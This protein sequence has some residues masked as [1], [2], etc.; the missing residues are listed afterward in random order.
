[1]KVSVVIPVHNGGKYLAQAIDSVLAQ[2]HRDLEL[3]I[4]DDG[5]TDGT[6]AI[7]R[8][9]ASMDQRVRCLSQINR[10]VAA[11]GNRG[12]EEAR[13]EWVARLDA[14]DIFL[15]EKLERQADFLRRNP[16]V[17]IVGALACFICRAGR[18]LGLV[19]TEGPFTRAEYDRL[20]RKNRPVYFVNSS[21][22]MHRETVL[23]AGGYREAFAPAEDVDLWIRMAERGHLMLKVPEAL[24]RYRL[25][26]ESLTMKQNARQRLLHRWAIACGKARVNG[27]PEPTLDDFV[28]G[29]NHRPV[30]ERARVLRREMG[31]RL[32]QQAA[33]HYAE[34]RPFRMILNLLASAVAHPAHVV[35]RLY[36]RKLQP[37]LIRPARTGMAVAGP[38]PAR[39]VYPC[40]PGH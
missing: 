30:I 31:E 14:D 18:P 34:Q 4:V 26:A 25:H 23:A 17:K 27:L 21:T 12:L 37:L 16:T 29:E 33:L 2:T 7:I 28:T 35:P 6:A 10:G 1:M 36:A 32:Y 39:E 38:D 22:L 20:V 19:G 13:S 11:A 40:A 15:P 5:S 8:H 9:Y 3:L 24:L